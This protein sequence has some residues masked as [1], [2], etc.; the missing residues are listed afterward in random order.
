VHAITT[1]LNL[2]LE[3]TSKIPS[4]FVQCSAGLYRTSCMKISSQHSLDLNFRR[5]REK[6][7]NYSQSHCHFQRV[8]PFLCEYCKRM[9]IVSRS[10]SGKMC[11][12]YSMPV[13]STSSGTTWVMAMGR[14]TRG[15]T[16]K[17][18]SGNIHRSGNVQGAFR[19][20]PGPIQGTSRAHSGNIQGPFREHP[21]NIQ[22]PFREHS[23]LPTFFPPRWSKVINRF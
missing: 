5:F 1:C 13:P 8:R 18:N 21:A 19:E 14:T 7:V 2:V 15:G 17:R 4:R 20:H 23:S 11:I 6:S 10:V 9:K 12:T 16:Q 3:H 22:G